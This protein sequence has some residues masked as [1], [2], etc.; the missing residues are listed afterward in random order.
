MVEEIAAEFRQ[1]K[2][3]SPS[4]TPDKLCLAGTALLRQQR[5]I[6]VA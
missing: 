1:R 2:L 6:A 3:E 5:L 4:V